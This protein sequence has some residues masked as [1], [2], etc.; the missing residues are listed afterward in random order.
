MNSSQVVPVPRRYAGFRTWREMAGQGRRYRPPK[1][2]RKIPRPRRPGFFRNLP[3]D[4]FDDPPVP[5]SER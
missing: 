3:P 2:D 5:R 4:P 1:V